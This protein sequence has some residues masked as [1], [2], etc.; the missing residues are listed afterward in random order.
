MKPAE[1]QHVNNLFMQY[2]QI[3]YIFNL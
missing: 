3:I 2:K 1:L